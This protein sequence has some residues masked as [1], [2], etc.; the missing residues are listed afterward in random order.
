MNLR[1]FFSLLLMLFALSLVASQTDHNMN[2]N[3]HS[4]SHESNDL[5][6][7]EREQ[8]VMPFDLEA[9]L[10][11]FQDTA[12]G[13]VQ[14]VIVHDANDQE[15]IDLI[16]IHLKEQAEAFAKGMF[17]NPSYLHGETMPGLAELQ[18]AGQ[19]GILSVVYQDLDNGGEIIYSSEDK[20]VIIAIHLWFQAQV[21]DHGDHATR[22]SQ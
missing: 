5:S 18:K 1:M 3:E 9:T 12:I 17:S 11:I 15:N 19:A 16:R 4:A 21:N 14:Q 8:A 22:V 10:H 6:F 2:H 7:A 20:D 13:G